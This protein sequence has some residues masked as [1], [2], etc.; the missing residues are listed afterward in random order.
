MFEAFYG[1][2]RTPFS[3][4]MDTDHVFL[5]HKTDETLARLQVAASRQWFAL[6]TGDC[7]TGKSTLVPSCLPGWPKRTITA[8]STWPTPS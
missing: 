3:H 4:G 7:G 2:E 5:T 8:F 6:L 1:L